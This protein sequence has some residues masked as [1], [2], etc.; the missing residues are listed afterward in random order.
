MLAGRYLA[1]IGLLA[2]LAPMGLLAGLQPAVAQVWTEGAVLNGHSDAIHGLV[3]SADRSTIASVS[4]PRVRNGGNEIR[5]LDVK[6]GKEQLR[7]SSPQDTVTCLLFSPDGKTLA[8]GSS[9]QTVKLWDTATGKER[10]GFNGHRFSIHALAFSP[11]GSKLAVASDH[12]AVLWD[13]NTG[14]EIS[15]FRRQSACWRPAFSP[16]LTL[17]ASANYQDIDLWD[18]AR[19]KERTTLPDHRGQ[20]A[21]MAFTADGKTLA[22]ASERLLEPGEYI[23]E[24]R[25]WDL[26]TGKEIRTLNAPAGVHCLRDMALSFDGKTLALLVAEHL[27]STTPQLQIMDVSTE[28]VV[29]VRKFKDRQAAPVCLRLS[30][31]GKLLATGFDDGS[32]RLWD[33]PAMPARP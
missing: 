5:L 21:C 19:G 27:L 20:V 12:A 3:F 2:G 11:D 30:P 28:K 10:A 8:I 23:V 16:D 1:L 4:T 14:T 26:T 6:A 13:V 18:V 29:A 15:S 17:L 32:L 22:A 25:F 7:F 33:V 24:F 9:D 31:D